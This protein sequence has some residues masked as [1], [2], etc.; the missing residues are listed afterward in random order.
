VCCYIF[1]YLHTDGVVRVL[2]VVDVRSSRPREEAASVA[3]PS[4]YLHVTEADDLPRSQPP[5]AVFSSKSVGG[6]A[7]DRAYSIER[8]TSS[9]GAVSPAQLSGDN[10][11]PEVSDGH[12]YEND[13]EPKKLR[14]QSRSADNLSEYVGMS[15]DSAARRSY[16]NDAGLY[17][18]ARNLDVLSGGSRDQPRKTSSIPTDLDDS[19]S[20]MGRHGNTSPPSTA[21]VS[22]DVDGGRSSPSVVSPV[23]GISM[24]TR[25][26]VFTRQK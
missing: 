15:G 3:L 10:V 16:E 7:L 14:Q 1:T 2:F 26:R 9:T 12:V 25:S 8:P 19:C 24:S 18:Y 20:S 5:L 23:A 21:V 17:S 11:S 13:A 6:A 22:C 4:Q